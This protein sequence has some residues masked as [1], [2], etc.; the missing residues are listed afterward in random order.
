MQKIPEEVLKLAQNYGF[1]K[2]VPHPIFDELYNGYNVYLAIE[3]IEKIAAST[4]L[5]NEKETRF[6]NAKEDK[7]L[8][9]YW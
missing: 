3:N 4:I 1:K 7:E 5:S 9:A 8:T 6:V 2:V